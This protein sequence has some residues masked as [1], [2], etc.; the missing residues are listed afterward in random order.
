MVNY[1]IIHILSIIPENGRCD[2][3]IALV[4][5]RKPPM[6]RI[7]VKTVRLGNRTYRGMEVYDYFQILPLLCFSRNSVGKI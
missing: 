1:G 4:T 7:R 2:F 6:M 5:A 3:L